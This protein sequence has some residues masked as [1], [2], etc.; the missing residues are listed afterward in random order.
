[1]PFYPPV[2]LLPKLLIKHNCFASQ[3]H[4]ICQLDNAL[5]DSPQVHIPEPQA[6][7]DDKLVKDGPGDRRR[8]LAQVAWIVENPAVAFGCQSK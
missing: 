7:R 5:R 2:K 3:R 1:M 6:E 8:V 4:L